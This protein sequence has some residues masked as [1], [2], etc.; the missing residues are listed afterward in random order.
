MDWMVTKAFGAATLNR[1][2]IRIYHKLGTYPAFGKCTVC[3]EGL[4]S[5]DTKNAPWQSQ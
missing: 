3:D 1:A 2:P 5:E 4:N